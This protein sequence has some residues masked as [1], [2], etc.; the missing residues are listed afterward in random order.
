MTFVGSTYFHESLTPSS[1][2]CPSP[3]PSTLALLACGLV[4]L[5]A[6]RRKLAR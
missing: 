1:D 5:L 6:A 3:E 2:P 4:G